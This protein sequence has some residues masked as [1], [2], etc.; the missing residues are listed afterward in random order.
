[1]RYARSEMLETRRN[2]PCPCGSG[3]KYKRC[4]LS[5][6]LCLV[7]EEFGE[8][9]IDRLSN[10]V[11][12]LIEAG[13]MDEAEEACRKLERKFPEHI[14]WIDRTA[15]LHEQRGDNTKAAEYF[16]RCFEFIENHPDGLDEGAKLYYQNSIQRLT[17][18][19]D[20]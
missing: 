12:D 5:T 9:E 3:K 8:L 19:N 14:D 16:R 17:G 1:M 18:K 11:L 7:V 2:D 20:H 6:G 10:R 15:R 13:R 4:C